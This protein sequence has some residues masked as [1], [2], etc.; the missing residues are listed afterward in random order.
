[1]SYQL[2]TTD[3]PLFTDGGEEAGFIDIRLIALLMNHEQ[4][5]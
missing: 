4:R 2:S 5:P 1:L 3:F